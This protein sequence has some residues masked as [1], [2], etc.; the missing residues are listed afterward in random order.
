MEGGLRMAKRWEMFTCTKCNKTER[1]FKQM[2]TDVKTGQ[3][4]T[5]LLI[6]EEQML[7]HFGGICPGAFQTK[8]KTRVLC[9][10]TCGCKVTVAVQSNHSLCAKCRRP[11]HRRGYAPRK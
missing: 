6:T 11:N 7:H 5:E 10:C 3:V 2:I 9:G 8:S 4:A 1:I